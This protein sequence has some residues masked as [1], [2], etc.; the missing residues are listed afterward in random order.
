MVVLEV[1]LHGRNVKERT[2]KEFLTRDEIK[3][4]RNLP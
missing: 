1:D 2:L 3:K 4:R